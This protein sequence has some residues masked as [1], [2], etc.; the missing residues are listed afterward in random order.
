MK[1]VFQ[2][3]NLKVSFAVGFSLKQSTKFR[4]LGASFWEK[5]K[6][7][8]KSKLWTPKLHQL[9]SI[10]KHSKSTL[11]MSYPSFPLFFLFFFSSSVICVFENLKVETWNCLSDYLPSAY[12][13]FIIK[14]NKIFNVFGN[15]VIDVDWQEIWLQPTFFFFFWPKEANLSKVSSLGVARIKQ[16][17]VARKSKNKK[18]NDKP[19]ESY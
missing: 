7:L 9:K 2:V 17:N 1:K 11:P 10:W 16:K 18:W 12:L 6:K 4:C 8:K 14:L 15:A 5:W 19:L 13:F 3:W